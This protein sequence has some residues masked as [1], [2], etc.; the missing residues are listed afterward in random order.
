MLECDLAT[1][2]FV[3]CSLTPGGPRQAALGT[4]ITNDPDQTAWLFL[5][6]RGPRAFH[7][8]GR[9]TSEVAAGSRK[10]AR[11]PSADAGASSFD[12]EDSGW[13][14]DAPAQ[15]GREHK[16]AA[17]TASAAALGGAVE[18]DEEGDIEVLLPGAEDEEVEYPSDADSEDFVRWMQA[19]AASGLARRPL[20]AAA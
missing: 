2:S 3:L 6:A 11:A 17:S 5:K 4:V 19:R 9:M 7:V 13:G 1:H 15:G 18:A 12:L 8:L 14:L 16:A 10:A 20:L